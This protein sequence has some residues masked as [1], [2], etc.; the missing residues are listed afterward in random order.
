MVKYHSQLMKDMGFKA[1]KPGPFNFLKPL[2]SVH[3]SLPF[4]MPP[5]NRGRCS[6]SSDDSD[7]FLYSTVSNFANF[8]GQKVAHSKEVCEAAK[9]QVKMEV[10]AVELKQ[11]TAATE[12]A[13]A[14]L[15]GAPEGTSAAAAVAAA[16]AA[17]AT[18][19]R[20]DNRV[21]R[22]L[23]GDLYV[24][25]S[26][27]DLYIRQNSGD[28]S[29]EFSSSVHAVSAGATGV[30]PPQVPVGA[31]IGKPMTLR[32]NS[33][34][35]SP[36][37]SAA[38]GDTSQISAPLLRLD[39]RGNSSLTF[40]GLSGTSAP[41][42]KLRASGLAKMASG[43]AMLEGGANSS[44]TP[45]GHRVVQQQGAL[46]R[47]AFRNGSNVHGIRRI[48]TYHGSEFRASSA[49]AVK[50][51]R[52][53]QSCHSTLTTRGSYQLQQVHQLMR[54]NTMRKSDESSRSGSVPSDDWCEVPTEQGPLIT[55]PQGRGKGS[56]SAKQ[57]VP[58][59]V[60]EGSFSC[61][62][63]EAEISGAFVIKAQQDALSFPRP[64]TKGGV[65]R[66]NS[67]LGKNALPSLSQQQQ[68]EKSGGSKAGKL[69]GLPFGRKGSSGSPS[70]SFTSAGGGKGLFSSFL[71]ARSGPSSKVPNMSADG[72]ARARSAGSSTSCKAPG[73]WP[74]SVGMPA[75]TQQQD[76]LAPVRQLVMQLQEHAEMERE[77]FQR[78]QGARATAACLGASLGDKRSS[79]R[80]VA[81]LAGNAVG[82][83]V[84]FAAEGPVTS[85]PA[86]SSD[87]FNDS[88][89]LS[90]PRSQA[91]QTGCAD[92]TTPPAAATE[93]VPRL[94]D[95]ASTCSGSRDA[96]HN[97]GPAALAGA[98]EQAMRVHKQGAA[99]N[100]LGGAAAAVAAA[101]GP[102]SSEF[103]AIS[104][105]MDWVNS[106]GS[107]RLS[108]AA[109][110]GLPAD[111]QKDVAARRRSSDCFPTTF[112][113][114]SSRPST[115]AASTNSS[116]WGS[117]TADG[118]DDCASIK[119]RLPRRSRS[120]R[121]LEAFQPQTAAPLL[122]LQE[123]QAVS[124]TQSDVKYSSKDTEALPIGTSGHQFYKK[125]ETKSLDLGSRV[126]SSASVQSVVSRSALDTWVEHV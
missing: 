67:G 106:G 54:M 3:Y 87:A 81:P 108:R 63:D 84:R 47:G 45:F 113:S 36:V 11:R 29:S 57:G 27:G 59:T 118:A 15:Q 51:A 100:R 49:A 68:V 16:A 23:S 102:E 24:R 112:N 20:V 110:S 41:L 62:T 123:L 13:A 46:D 6:F 21:A 93:A 97:I 77:R 64:K 117:G 72:S 92:A 73:A 91:S 30:V 101:L 52:R 126:F 88:I 105:W 28:L 5:A 55:A 85:A 89:A 14:L 82:P 42:P 76:P 22:T 1:P 99:R 40:P 74:G 37:M 122:Y 104:E 86:A 50:G 69:L 9:Q 39:T 78:E 38:H 60:F 90:F 111:A 32:C 4:T 58:S 53:V 19:V 120:S 96:I 26:S 17:G 25:A 124:T 35:E 48:R 107:S 119:R 109:S 98:A 125:R 75:G 8:E 79:I 43:T 31:A 34:P 116:A 83:R 7:G 103:Q 44:M 94:C 61:S 18:A 114:S 115:Q 33:Q 56:F 12:A 121:A 95:K 2:D 66:Q 65:V 71:K 80:S 70:S 10:S